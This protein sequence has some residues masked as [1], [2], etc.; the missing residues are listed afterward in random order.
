MVVTIPEFYCHFPLRGIYVSSIFFSERIC[1]LVF[2]VICLAKY[3]L[4]DITFSL[5]VW[6]YLFLCL[7]VLP[8]HCALLLFL[9]NRDYIPINF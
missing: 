8:V 7:T 6:M 1:L 4:V 9:R 5:Y 3:F 2:L